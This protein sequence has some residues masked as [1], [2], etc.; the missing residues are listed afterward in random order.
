MSLKQD[1]FEERKKIVEE[2]ASIFAYSAG[3]GHINL[4]NEKLT[5]YPSWKISE[6][7]ESTKSNKFDITITVSF[8][9]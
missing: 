6:I 4:K 5:G 3:T 9:K 8:K 1:S 2:L 7:K